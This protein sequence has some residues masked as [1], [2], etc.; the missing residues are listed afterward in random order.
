MGPSSNSPSCLNT[1]EDGG[2]ESQLLCRRLIFFE[3]QT[4]LQHAPTSESCT[5]RRAVSTPGTPILLPPRACGWQ[6]GAQ[7]LGRRAHARRCIVHMCS[8]AEKHLLMRVYCPRKACRN[9]VLCRLG[10]KGYMHSLSILQDDRVN[11]EQI[12]PSASTN[13]KATLRARGTVPKAVLSFT[14]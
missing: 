13:R 4:C 3:V 14:G 1:S 7:S 11:C 5:L 2:R 8:M 6:G 10:W 9:Q 12:R